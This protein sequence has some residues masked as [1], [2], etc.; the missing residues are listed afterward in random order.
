MIELK[1]YDT[2]LKEYQAAEKKLIEV[3]E[4]HLAI[5]VYY[6]LT[7]F[8]FFKEVSWNHGMS[9]FNDGDPSYFRRSDLIVTTL[10]GDDF[11]GGIINKEDKLETL[12]EDLA[13]AL[14]YVSIDDEDHRFKVYRKWYNTTRSD[15]I[16][17]GYEYLENPEK[18]KCSIEALRNMPENVDEHI[19]VLSSF[20]ENIEEHILVKIYG[21]DIKVVYDKDGY[22][23][24]DYYS[25][26]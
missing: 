9:G 3:T 19:Q 7:R 11:E 16:D 21:T 5:E 4:R 22:T 15:D 17:D 18:I 12:Q 20:V 14:E 23:T 1:N 6:F 26:Y 2:I 25:D 13:L 10:N 8:P 24:D